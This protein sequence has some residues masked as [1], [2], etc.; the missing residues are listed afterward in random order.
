MIYRVL[1]V[2]MESKL[3]ST[4]IVGKRRLYTAESPTHLK[5]IV[6]K[7]S[8]DFDSILPSMEELYTPRTDQPL[9]KYYSGA[10]GIT[11]LFDDVIRTLKK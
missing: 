8:D 10:K 2:L 1:P 4:S 5:A 11:F 9:I 3:L 6:D 7:L